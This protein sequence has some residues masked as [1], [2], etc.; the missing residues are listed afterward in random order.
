MFHL[1]G[2]NRATFRPP[3]NIELPR[4]VLRETGQSMESR[5]LSNSLEACIEDTVST[6]SHESA[7]LSLGSSLDYVKFLH[8]YLDV[9]GS[10]SLTRFVFGSDFVGVYGPR[11]RGVDHAQR[12]G[13][14]VRNKES[15]INGVLEVPFER[16][17]AAVPDAKAYE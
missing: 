1:L 9:A 7:S 17:C 12:Y 8:G 10:V 3:Q 13:H 16:L 11:D 14:S 6:A 15:R 4:E 5:A 2:N